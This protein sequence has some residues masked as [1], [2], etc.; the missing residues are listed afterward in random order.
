MTT[1]NS[2]I[3]A[4]H[5]AI[6]RFVHSQ[7]LANISMLVHDM[8]QS[9]PTADLADD[10]ATLM[11]APADYE[12]PCT[13]AGWRLVPAEDDDLDLDLVAQHTDGDVY[14]LST[15]DCR[16]AWVDLAALES[17]DPYEREIYEYWIVTSDLTRWLTDAGERVATLSGLDIWARTTTGQAICMDRV[18]E[19][20]FAGRVELSDRWLD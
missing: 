1:F 9:D 3:P 6:E 11:Y 20:I 5:R 13:D 8:S 2:R 14:E 17:I 18:I 4:H 16:E 12:T 15:S 7:V 19:D 10:L